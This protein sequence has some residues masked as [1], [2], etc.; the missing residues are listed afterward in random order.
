MISH[1]PVHRP[2]KRSLPTRGWSFD[3]PSRWTK[4][5]GV[6]SDPRIRVH[7]IP[8]EL[9]CF[10]TRKRDVFFT[11]QVDF[12]LIPLVLVQM[13]KSITSILRMGKSSMHNLPMRPYGAQA[14]K[15]GDEP[16]SP[17]QAQAFK[18]M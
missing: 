2:L 1:T 4:G 18:E 14:Y 10:L 11:F 7:P 12:E 13:N 5:G 6:W 17:R 3:K 15:K 8:S 9:F 16:Q